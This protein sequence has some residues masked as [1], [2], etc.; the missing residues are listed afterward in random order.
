MEIAIGAGGFVER[1][2]AVSLSFYK[3]CVK[4]KEIKQRLPGY[5]S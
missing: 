5:F 3:N 1:R 4:G 2:V